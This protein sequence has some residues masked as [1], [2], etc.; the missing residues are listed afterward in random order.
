MEETGLYGTDQTE[1]FPIRSK[2]GHNYIFFLYNY[3]PNNIMAK[4]MKNRTDEEF[5]RVH[6]EVI[7]ELTSERVKSTI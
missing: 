1:K 4:P 7:D 2:R 6:D 3:D 5:I